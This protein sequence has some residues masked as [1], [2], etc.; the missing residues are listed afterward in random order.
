MSRCCILVLLDGLGDRSY[1]E[2]GGKTPLQA[3]FTP[4]LDR[5]CAEGGNGYLWALRPGIALPSENAHFAIFG[6]E[7]QE[8]PGRGYLEALGGQ[9]GVGR[10]EVALL[11]H[12]ASLVPEN[13]TLRLVKHR[14]QSSEE[15]ADALSAA[16]GSFESDGIAIRY[17]QTKGL[18]GVVIMHGPVSPAIT[19][20][21][22]LEIN[23]PLVEVE[24]LAALSSDIKADNTARALKQYLV[25]CHETLS[26]LPLNTGRMKMGI[27]PVNGLVTQ[28][29]GKWRGVAPFSDRWGLKGVSL[30]SG[31]MYWGL[32]FFLGMDKVE[33]ADGKDPGKDLADRLRR[34]LELRHDYDF[35]HVHTKAPDAAAHSKNPLNKVD[36]IESLDRGLGQVI[37]RLLDDEIVLVIT[38]DHSTPSA[39]PMVHSGESVPFTVAGPGIRC[40]LVRMFDEVSCTAGALGRISG[41]DFMYLVLNW[42]DRAKLQGLM[43]TPVNQPFWPGKRTAFRMK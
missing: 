10:D 4:H 2:L 21:D 26:A 36:A 24:P 41:S 18:D 8:F 37:D 12:F 6:Y 27:E 16:V 20:S 1:K 11:A 22:P 31:L 14:P 40:D 32:A 7:Q 43:D 34:A 3:A 13:N 5:F 42:L 28:R 15:E 19:D 9:T 39:G 29:A 25:W 33:V 35:I 30:S 38:A 17:H 23:S